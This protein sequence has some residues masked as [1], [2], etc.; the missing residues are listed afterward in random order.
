[1]IEAKFAVAAKDE[2]SMIRV[3]TSICVRRIIWF[4]HAEGGIGESQPIRFP[5]RTFEL[6]YSAG[7]L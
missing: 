5:A 7:T 3:F 6:E 4:G 2:K 1:M